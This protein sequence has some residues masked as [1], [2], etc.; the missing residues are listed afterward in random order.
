M[1]EQEQKVEIPEVEKQEEVVVEETQQAE[2]S[3][4]FD[5]LEEDRKSVV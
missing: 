5:P 2:H 1:S 4:E 3:Q